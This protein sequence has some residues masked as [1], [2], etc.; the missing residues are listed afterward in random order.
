MT[1]ARQDGHEPVHRIEAPPSM[2]ALAEKALRSMILSGDLRPGDRVVENQLTAELGVSRPPLREAMRVLQQQGLLVQIPRKGAIVT[3]LTAHDIYEIVTLREEVEKLAV[4]LGVPVRSQERLERLRRAFTDLEE[5]AASSDSAH[6]TECSFAFHL[7]I[8][9]LAGHRRLEDIY[10]SLSLQMQL[11][12]AMNRKMRSSIE[13]PSEDAARHRPLLEL[14]EAGDVEGMLHRI[15]HHGQ[16]TFLL[17]IDD[18]FEGHSPESR[19]WLARIREEERLEEERGRA[20]H[21]TT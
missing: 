9:G 10:R 3:P 2:S 16:R 11:Y 5:A 21:P 20:E 17:S 14:V 15:Q 18:H 8:V 19:A 12:M 13:T 1:Q 7:A 4:R 6:V